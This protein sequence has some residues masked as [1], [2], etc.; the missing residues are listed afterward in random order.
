[1]TVYEIFH[2]VKRLFVWTSDT[3]RWQTAEHWTSYADD[4]ERGLIIRDDCDAFALTCVELCVRAGMHPADLA[5]VFCRTET[6][7]AHLVGRYRN[8]VLDNRQRRVLLMCRIPYVWQSEMKMSMRGT[9]LTVDASTG[10]SQ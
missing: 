9:W 7:E 4:A 6:G 3:E 2:L 5:V 8:T 10:E 1:M